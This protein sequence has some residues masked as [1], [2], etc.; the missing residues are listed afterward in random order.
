MQVIHT[1]LIWLAVWVGSSVVLA[2]LLGRWLRNCTE[3]S[4]ED[5]LTQSSSELLLDG[6]KFLD[7]D[8][9]VEQPR[10]SKELLTKKAAA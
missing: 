4:L 9:P 10:D 8:L 1:V 6:L 7:S 2:P 3:D 5:S